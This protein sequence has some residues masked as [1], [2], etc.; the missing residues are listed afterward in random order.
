M[1]SPG[2]MKRS[3]VGLGFTAE[4]LGAEK[5]P[6]NRG[7]AGAWDTPLFVMY[8]QLMGSNPP[9]M[10]LLHALVFSIPVFWFC[11]RLSI[12]IAAQYW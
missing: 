4:K 7:F 9:K 1:R 10:K 12:V 11:V 5:V 8:A 3:F 6:V 2:L